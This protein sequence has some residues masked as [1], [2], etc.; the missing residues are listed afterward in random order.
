M[1]SSQ[2]KEQIQRII[3]EQNKILAAGPSFAV[4]RAA[5]KVKLEAMKKLGMI[6]NSNT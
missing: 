1:L 2:E 3:A 4:K 5:Q 6:P